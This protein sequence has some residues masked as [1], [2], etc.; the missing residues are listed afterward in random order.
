M[1]RLGSGLRG[2]RTPGPAPPAPGPGC[3]LGFGFW[4]VSGLR[5]FRDR[6]V[7]EREREGEREREK[8]FRQ[9]RMQK[10]VEGF[11]FRL[12]GLKGLEGKK[13]WGSK[14]LASAGL[15][16]VLGF[17]GIVAGKLWTRAIMVKGRAPTLSAIHE[18]FTGACAF[19]DGF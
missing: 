3:D 9:V 11:V 5:G 13:G 12:S 19:F 7:R 15:S 16:R 14:G 6:D 10:K 8:G 1:P 17:G 2:L 4:G 18:G